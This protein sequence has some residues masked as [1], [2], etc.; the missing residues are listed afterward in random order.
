VVA[1]SVCC[2]PVG[3]SSYLESLEQLLSCVSSRAAP[4]NLTVRTVI[5]SDC[6]NSTTAFFTGSPSSAA[7]NSNLNKS[8]LVS[9][10]PYLMKLLSTGCSQAFEIG[11][12]GKVHRVS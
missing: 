1:A 7:A 10:T 11:H 2:C 12:L 5:A 8:Q 3:S 6:Q 4:L 9:A